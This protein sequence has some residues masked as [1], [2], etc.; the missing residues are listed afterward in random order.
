[1]KKREKKSREI[2]VKTDCTVVACWTDKVK[3]IKNI[4]IIFEYDVTLY[5]PHCMFLIFSLVKSELTPGFSLT[6]SK[7]DDDLKMPDYDEE[8][9]AKIS[10]KVVLIIKNQLRKLL[11]PD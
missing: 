6:E 1:M 3:L 2:E 7:D 4:N 9:Q 8:A 10:G 5:S 11:C